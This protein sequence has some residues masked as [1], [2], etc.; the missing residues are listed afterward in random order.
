MNTSP[1]GIVIKQQ[2]EGQVRDALV[3]ELGSSARDLT[4]SFTP[5]EHDAW[6]VFVRGRVQPST[7]LP[8]S[9]FEGSL[10]KTTD[11]KHP[12]VA[13]MNG[14]RVYQGLRIA[15]ALLF[16]SKAAIEDTN[17]QAPRRASATIT[18]LE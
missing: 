3:R 17:L 7:T 6:R 11:L 4:V 2:R 13:Q 9:P 1:I 16:L 8:A 18:V 5:L 12:F 10:S 15:D 14:K